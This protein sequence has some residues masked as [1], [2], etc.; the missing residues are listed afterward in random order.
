MRIAVVKSGTRLNVLFP[1]IRVREWEGY[2]HN[3][4]DICSALSELGHE[5]LPISDGK[6]LPTMLERLRIDMAWVCSGGIQGRDP[7]AHLPSILEMLGVPYVG[8]PPLAA[9]MADHKATTR[10]V[11]RFNGVPVP[12]MFV[13]KDAGFAIPSSLAFPL[14]VKP[15]HG[16]GGCRVHRVFDE[17]T[18]RQ[19]C[20]EITSRYATEALV[21]QFIP[22]SDVTVPIIE[23]CAAPMAL[24]PLR[25]HLA[26]QDEV[27][28]FSQEF[29]AEHTES[30][31]LEAPLAASAIDVPHRER[32]IE[33][34][35]RMFR[36]L[37]IRHAGRFDF[38]C[39]DSDAILLEANAKPD[40]RRNSLMAASAAAAGLSHTELIA[41]ILSAATQ[42]D[43][44]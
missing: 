14:V 41:Q 12:E 33:L 24:P 17:L 34:A 22:G 11:A 44:M 30:T 28:P 5:A 3:A 2:E 15:V 18:L 6:E 21:E 43:R 8:S 7:L 38:R 4:R 16:F 29:I 32:V 42:S 1:N 19:R 27:E 31:V 23:Q 26:W 35:T 39:T 20:T 9:G 37:R 36:A 10:Q 40:L 13:A 25:R